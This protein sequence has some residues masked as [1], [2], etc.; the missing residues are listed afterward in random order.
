[1]KPTKLKRSFYDRPTLEVA[2]D[3]LGKILIY[4]NDGEKLGGRLVEGVSC[5]IGADT[6]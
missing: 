2:P 6:P 3:L 1:M 5:Q 4:E